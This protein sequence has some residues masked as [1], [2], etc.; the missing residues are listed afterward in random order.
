MGHHCEL[1]IHVSITANLALSL[2]VLVHILT[3][4][5]P[6][7]VINRTSDG[8]TNYSFVE[9]MFMATIPNINLIWGIKVRYQQSP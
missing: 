1:T 7:N 8:Y 3:F 6:N 5:I 2:G 9:K 4:F